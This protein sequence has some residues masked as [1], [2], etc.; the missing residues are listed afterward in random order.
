[1]STVVLQPPQGPCCSGKY[2][3]LNRST[4]YRFTAVTRHHPYPPASIYASIN[5][6]HSFPYPLLSVLLLNLLLR[7]VVGN[8]VLGTAMISLYPVNYTIAVCILDG[9]AMT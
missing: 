7:P 2:L 6:A 3:I 8:T 9:L 1:M 4:I 5:P